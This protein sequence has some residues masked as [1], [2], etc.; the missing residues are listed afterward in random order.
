MR[1]VRASNQPKR[2]LSARIVSEARDTTTLIADLTREMKALASTPI[3]SVETTLLIHPHVLGDFLAYNDFLAVA[4][5]RVA[6]LG[7]EGVLQI[8]SFHP[9]Y[10]FAESEAD[11]VE[12]YTNR[13]PHPMLHLLREDSVSA[14]ANDPDELLEIPRRNVETLRRMGLRKILEMK[15][16]IEEA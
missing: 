16:I 12:D 7:F 10:R 14:V 5:H 2:G 8:A 11:A 4:D 9:A 13:S 15:A 6:D 3:R 1:S